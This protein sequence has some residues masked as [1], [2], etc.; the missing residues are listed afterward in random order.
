MYSYL[1]VYVDINGATMLYF[2]VTPLLWLCDLD[3]FYLFEFFCITMLWFW[4]W[5]NYLIEMRFLNYN[6]RSV[7]IYNFHNIKNLKH[8]SLDHYW[9]SMWPI[10]FL[11]WNLSLAY[12][13]KA[14]HFVTIMKNWITNIGPNQ[15]YFALETNLCTLTILFSILNYKQLSCNKIIF[16]MKNNWINIFPETSDR[17]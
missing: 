11:V 8:K 13:A 5:H 16:F 7:P 15:T 12:W 14:S 6:K 1:M 3:F 4:K 17:K 9:L 2:S 10:R